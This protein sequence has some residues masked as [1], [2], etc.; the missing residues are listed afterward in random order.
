MTSKKISQNKVDYFRTTI[1]KWYIQYGRKYPWRERGLSIYEYIIAEVLLQRTRADIV[2]GVYLPFIKNFEDW[3]AIVNSDLSEIEKYLK[4]LGL[5]RQKAH[6]LSKL[7][8]EM[9]LLGGILPT[10]RE[11]IEKMPFMG[12]YISNSVELII[13]NRKKPLLDVN[14]SRVL[15]RFF[16]KRKLADIRYDPYLQNLALRI[17][18]IGK[19]KEL[20]WGIL[21]FA[22]LICKA[23]RPLCIECQ[24]KAKCTF[25]KN[26]KH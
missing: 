26:V 11:E 23:I 24:L 16:G 14:M 13:F 4:P 1:L 2:S 19:S 10:R 21:D 20:S 22:A 25:F 5:Y 3:D 17:V 12:Q 18:N 6:R 7:A 9:K 15:E 8:Q